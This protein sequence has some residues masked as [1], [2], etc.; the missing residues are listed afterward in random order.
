M[1]T[2]ANVEKRFGSGLLALSDVSFRVEVG[3]FV[4][5]IGPS[6]CGKSTILA[7]VAG[8]AVATAG[9][10]RVDLPESQRG[11]GAFAAVFQDAALMPWARILSNVTLP[12][13]LRGV[14]LAHAKETARAALAKVGLGGFENAFPRQLSGGMRMRASLARA[15]VTSP[16]ILLLDEPFAAVDEITRKAL[17][18]DLAVLM[19]P[20]SA[21][22]TL[23]VTHSVEEAAF[24]SDR[25]YVMTPRPGRIVQVVETPRVLRRQ[26]QWAASN[27][28]IETCRTLSRSLAEAKDHT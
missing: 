22:T 26:S 3:E 10:A 14:P 6:G 21:P 27:A 1:I 16:R 23:L 7:L 24:L 25:T 8:L 19:E 5:F 28:Y 4:S 15:L 12:L 9:E 20:P 17:V 13:R 11:P 2:F 18:N